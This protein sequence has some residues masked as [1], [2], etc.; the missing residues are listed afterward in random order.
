MKK[1]SAAKPWILGLAPILFTAFGAF[2]QGKACMPADMAAAEKAADRVVNWEQLYKAFQDYGHCDKGSVDE[3]FTEALLRCIV[4]WKNVE[5]LARPMEKDKAYRE[6]VYRH[7]GSPAAKSDVDSVYSRA[8]LSCPKGLDG[9]CTQ[10]ASAVKPFAGME[11]AT[12]VAAPAAADPKT[13]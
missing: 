10:I 4:E 7:L 9:F 12:P 8:K 3:I 13:K 1:H 11:L 6:F 2:A 5:G